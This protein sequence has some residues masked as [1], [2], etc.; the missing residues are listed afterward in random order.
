[1]QLDARVLGQPTA[2]D[3]VLVGGVVVAD[4][5]QPPARV[6]AGDLL[7]EGQELLVAVAGSA[8]VGDAPGGDLQGGKQRGRPVPQVVMG[9]LLGPPGP[10]PAHGLGTFQGLNLGLLVHAEHHGPLRWVPVQ[11]DDV[12]D[13]GRQLGSVENLKVSARQ[14]W[15]PYSRQMR[16]MVSR[17]TPSSRARSR[18]DQWVMPSR[19][20]AG[21]RV[22]DKISARRARPTLWGRPGRGR[23]GNPP[24]PRRTYRPRQV[25]TVGRET[26]TRSAISVL[27][28]PSAARSRMRARCASTF[29]SRL[30]R[31]HR[32]S[33]ARSSGATGSGEAAG[34]LHTPMPRQI[35]KLLQRRSTRR[36]C[37]R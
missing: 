10:D 18:V 9:A 27:V 16:A 13:L 30:D 28:T 20:G 29:G 35:V 4:H 7:E 22:T 12:V 14:G 32:R 34:M 25:M 24:S 1:V 17:L 5:V 3:W 2:D 33:S 6:G 11:A 21:L 15:M 36:L 31:T 26:P 8:L 23:S 37:R 19:G